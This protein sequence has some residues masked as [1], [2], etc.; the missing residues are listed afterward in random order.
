MGYT[1][2]GTYLVPYTP[3]VHLMPP[4]LHKYVDK[5]RQQDEIDEQR[6]P[7]NLHVSSYRY[8]F[9]LIRKY[10]KNRNKRRN[11]TQIARITPFFAPLVER[12]SEVNRAIGMEHEEYVTVCRADCLQFLY[13]K[14]SHLA[15]DRKEPYPSSPGYLLHA[16]AATVLQSHLP[17]SLSCGRTPAVYFLPSAQPCS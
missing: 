4:I 5:D 3:F 7:R 14:L 12:K 2:K 11:K 17:A 6:P 8:F 16:R 1:D 9:K 13:K 10:G 15:S